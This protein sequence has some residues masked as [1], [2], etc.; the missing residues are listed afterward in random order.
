MNTRVFFVLLVLILI[1]LLAF[2]DTT[3]SYTGNHFTDF[4]GNAIVHTTANYVSGSFVVAAP[5]I[6]LPNGSEIT[7]ISFSFTDGLSTLTQANCDPTCLFKLETNASGDLTSWNIVLLNTAGDALVSTT[8]FGSGGDYGAIGSVSLGW[9]TGNPG[10]WRVSS[11]NPGGAVP[12]PAS[13]M[14]LGS[15]FSVI[16]LRFRRRA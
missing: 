13:L 5:L 9:V 15:G 14:L 2:A 7:P 11:D 6:S 12:E 3:Y 1:P 10:T 8:N 4:N 16:V